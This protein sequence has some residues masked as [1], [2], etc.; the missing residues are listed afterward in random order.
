MSHPRRFSEVS[1]FVLAGGASRRMGLDKASLPMGSERLV[2]RQIRLLRSVCRSVSIIGPPHRFADLGIRVYED[3]IPG[4]GPLG[5]IY[6]GLRKART[7]FSLFLS[8]DMPFAEARFLRYLCQE[9][10]ARRAPVTVPPPWTKG[11]YPLCAILRRS[12]LPAVRSSL[13]SGQ[14]RLGRLFSKARCRT[15]S[16]AE[17]ARAGF[18]PRIFC[19]LNTRE[20]YE[21]VRRQFDALA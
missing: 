10:L 6:T 18:S 17:F 21:K 14:N 8:C 12:A 15:I 16:K 20:E 13:A 4:K 11:R 9:A 7:E 2:D 19:N 1:G 3:D 5:G